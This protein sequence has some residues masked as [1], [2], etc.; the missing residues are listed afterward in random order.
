MQMGILDWLI[1]GGYLAALGAVG[2]VATLRVKNTGQYFLGGRRFG[3]LLR[4]AQNFGVSTHAEMP[5]SLAGAVYSM[6]I[7]AIWYQWKSLFAMPFYWIMAPVFR[8]VRRTTSAEMM[9]N[10][11]G[12]G[13]GGSMFCSPSSTSPLASRVS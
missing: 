12:P 3:K 8:R 13:M 1:V 10:R 5:V 7:S 11:Y 2:I 9:E 4:V 6:G